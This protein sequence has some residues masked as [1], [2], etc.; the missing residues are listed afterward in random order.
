MI[1][2][3]N[4]TTA[5]YDKLMNHIDFEELKKDIEKSKKNEYKGFDN[6][7]DK[8]KNPKKIEKSIRKAIASEKATKARTKK[9]KAKIDNA[10]NIL[11]MECKKITHYSI[12]KTGDVAYLTVK[13]YLTDDDIISLNK[14]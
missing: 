3:L 6:L 9:A 11:R 12:A 1:Y 8:I 5:E 13:K 10:I 2:R 7:V 14:I 4:L